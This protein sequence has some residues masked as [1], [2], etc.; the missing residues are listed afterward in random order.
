VQDLAA[1][2]AGS[3]IDGA[4]QQEN[5]GDAL[6]EGL[7]PNLRERGALISKPVTIAAQPNATQE[8]WDEMTLR[9]WLEQA[10]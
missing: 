10:T 1:D 3:L 8:D 4:M 6:V 5:V 2:P 7:M 9:G